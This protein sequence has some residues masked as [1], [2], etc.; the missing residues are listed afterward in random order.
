VLADERGFQINLATEPVD[1]AGDKAVVVSPRGDIDM[2]TAGE[3]RE[4]LIRLVAAGMGHVIVDLAGVTFMDSSGL[5]VLAAAAK[6]LHAANGRLVVRNAGPQARQ[7]LEITALD[8]LLEV[9]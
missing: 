2:A 8:R 1:G 9:E 4:M 5:S 3:L 7:I 6:R